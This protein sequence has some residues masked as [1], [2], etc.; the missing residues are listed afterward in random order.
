MVLDTHSQFTTLDVSLPKLVLTP[1][2]KKTLAGTCDFEIISEFLQEFL[3]VN[4]CHV[5][6]KA[7]LKDADDYISWKDY[8]RD[9][10]RESCW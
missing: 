2:E 8:L 4:S 6:T 9:C 5:R 1:T 7:L 10:L 3:V